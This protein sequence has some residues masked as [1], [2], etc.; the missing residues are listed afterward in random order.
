MNSLEKKTALQLVRMGIGGELTKIPKGLDHDRLLGILTDQGVLCVA[1]DGLER[2]VAALGRDG[3]PKGFVL[4]LYALKAQVMQ[5]ME[6]KRS[7]ICRFAE[8]MKPHK[9]IVLK[10]IGFASYWPNP[11]Y[12]EYGDFDCYFGEGFGEVN[13]KAEAVGARVEHGTHKHSHILYRGLMIENHQNLTDYDGSRI[14]DF[15]EKTLYALL[16]GQKAEKLDIGELYSP[17]ELFT[18]CFMLK[19]AQGH[20][21]SEGIEL[22]HFLDWIFFVDK[23]GGGFDWDR[24]DCLLDEMRVRRFADMVFSYCETRLGWKSPHAYNPVPEELLARVDDFVFSGKSDVLNRNPFYILRRF[25]KRFCRAWH[26]RSLNS[27]SFLHYLWTSIAY[28]S[29][30]DRKPVYNR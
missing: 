12:R 30:F 7:L 11:L 16:N 15:T 29:I 26:F 20:F 10:G 5:G 9:A 27:I 17:N 24:F 25:A 4:Q 1:F 2:M 21:M 14:G 6:S 8:K 23:V 3:V 22:R 19:H 28:A 18:A 13:A